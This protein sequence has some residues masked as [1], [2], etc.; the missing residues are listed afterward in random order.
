MRFVDQ[1]PNRMPVAR[2]G[3]KLRAAS[4]SS[5]SDSSGSD[6][7]WGSDSETADS[8]SDSQS[9]SPPSPS[10]SKESLQLL[11]TPNTPHPAQTLVNLESSSYGSGYV[12]I[13]LGIAGPLLIDSVLTQIP[14]ATLQRGLVQ[15]TSR[16][17]RALNANGGVKTTLTDDGISRGYCIEFESIT[18][19]A[20]ATKWLEAGREEVR[21][22][23]G[24]LA[25]K[26]TFESAGGFATLVSIE[27]T[28]TGRKVYVSASVFSCMKSCSYGEI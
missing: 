21:G 8:L 23:G 26:Q 5:S 1:L 22:G 17:C 25:L 15:N 13:P 10:G 7:S 3:R 2:P 14:M 6:W 19:A 16:G 18:Q 27:C 12:P 20:V 28:P 11:A 24:Y 4:I 9:S